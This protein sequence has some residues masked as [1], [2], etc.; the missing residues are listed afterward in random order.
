MN[1]KDKLEFHKWRRQLME[2]RKEALSRKDQLTISKCNKLL[3]KD[4]TAWA[5][6]VQLEKRKNAHNNS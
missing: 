4:P 6:M 1:N 5:E 2:E 3:Q